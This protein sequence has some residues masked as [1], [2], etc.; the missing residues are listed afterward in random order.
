MAAQ[1]KPGSSGATATVATVERSPWVVWWRWRGCR[2]TWALKGRAAAAGV[3]RAG[4]GEVAAVALL[5]GGVLRRRQAEEAH[6]LARGGEAAQVAE[7]GE[8][9]E[10]G[11]RGDAAKTAQPAHRV[12]PRLTRGDLVELVVERGDLRVEA[13]EVGEHVLQRRLGERIAEALA[14]DPRLVGLGPA[15]LALAEDVAVAQQ[16]LG[17]AVARGAARADEV[18]A[19]AHR[20]L[21]VGDLLEAQLGARIVGL[22]GAHDRALVD[23]QRGAHPH[24]RRRAGDNVRH[25][26][27]LLRM[28]LWPRRPSTIRWTLTRDT[29]GR[30]GQPRRVHAD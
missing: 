23:I 12:A 30:E 20:P 18:V 6:Q 19:A 21:G 4:L 25:G 11:D 3:A 22:G 14:A 13:V 26:L 8:Q 5:A 2:R 24:R 15:L 17:D 28:R 9:P 10:R 27:V 7:L 1:R 29:C 16:L